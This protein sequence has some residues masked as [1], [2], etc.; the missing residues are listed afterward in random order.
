MPLRIPKKHA[1]I[2]KYSG[3][4]RNNPYAPET[5]TDQKTPEEST[6]DQ[7]RLEETRD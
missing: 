2:Q 4:F 1:Q 6:G 5:R 3:K 7:K